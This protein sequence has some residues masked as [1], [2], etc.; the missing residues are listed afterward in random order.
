MNF[1]PDYPPRA[2]SNEGLKA[3]FRK[4]GT[5]LAL[6]LSLTSA[7]S[8]AFSAVKDPVGKEVTPLAGGE[9]YRG[10]IYSSAEELKKESTI[11]LTNYFEVDKANISSE[12]IE[13]IKGDFDKFLASI[14]SQN[15]AQ[16]LKTN[17]VVYSS[18]DP[19]PTNNPEWKGLNVN[20]AVARANA[21][22]E[23]L[24]QALAVHDFS[25]SGLTEAQI[26]ALKS[27]PFSEDH[28]KTEKTGA[29]EGVTPLTEFIDEDTGQKY[30]EEKIDA[31]IKQNDPKIDMLRQQARNVAFSLR[32]VDEK[33]FASPQIPQNLVPEMFKYNTVIVGV[34]NS[35]S[36]KESKDLLAKAFADSTMKLPDHLLVGTFS[37]DVDKI[38]PT[39]NPSKTL[40]EQ[41]TGMESGEE[42]VAGFFNRAFTLL[43][44]EMKKVPEGTV[45]ERGAIFAVTDESVQDLSRERLDS[46]KA[47]SEQANCDVY[48]L[49]L[50][51]VAN[52]PILVSLADLERS[53]DL[54]FEEARKGNTEIKQKM[55]LFENA[56]IPNAE[57][58]VANAT[59]EK[60][61]AKAQAEL[62]TI[63][64]KKADY[65]QKTVVPVKTFV[66]GDTA[67]L[68]ATR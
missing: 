55:D 32:V 48:V 40:N 47:K 31:M 30:T 64:K 25:G 3:K 52:K 44:E 19:W 58:K 62:D 35:P 61:K 68:M 46:L 53:F 45:K 2:T 41:F 36:M 33:N 28:P 43:D 27:I 42:R 66:V 67:Y 12:N 51:H 16:I 23:G 29:E 21:V 7:A 14:D 60:E 5:R 63:L 56:W 54:A 20:L 59:S 10:K 1:K 18:C 13:K 15:I 39:T 6:A 49:I 9:M 22:I 65:I 34:D 26:T 8:P 37:Y 17:F 24:K 11:D 38:V 57:K 50:N 4:W